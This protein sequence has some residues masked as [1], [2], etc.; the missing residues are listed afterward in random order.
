[1]RDVLRATELVSLPTAVTSLATTLHYAAY[2]GSVPLRSK[3]RASS[4]RP[5]LAVFVGCPASSSHARLVPCDGLHPQTRMQLLGLA[6]SVR[7]CPTLQAASLGWC[8]P[9]PHSRRST[10]LRSIAIACVHGA[11]RP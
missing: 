11:L 6:C 1:M 10:V 5:S 2:G 4:D 9:H 3:R 8:F 7:L